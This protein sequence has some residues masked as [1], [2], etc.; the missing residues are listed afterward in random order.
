M[1]Q[2]ASVHHHHR[3]NLRVLHVNLV[4][5]RDEIGCSFASAVLGPGDGRHSLPYQRNRL[6]LDGRGLVGPAR[7]EGQDDIFLELQLSKRLVFG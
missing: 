6:L 4:Q 3:L 1:G 5:N 7:G 2:L